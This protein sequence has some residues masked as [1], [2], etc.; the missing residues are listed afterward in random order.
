[1]AS[2]HA[3]KYSC[4]LSIP[5]D[6]LTNDLGSQLMLEVSKSYVINLGYLLT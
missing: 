1:M 3:Y 2:H 6:W 4:G 5:Y